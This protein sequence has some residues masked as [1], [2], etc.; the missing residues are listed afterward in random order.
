MKP[1]I[2]FLVAAAAMYAAAPACSE[3]PLAPLARCL[4]DRAIALADQGHADEARTEFLKAISLWRELG[5][6]FDPHRA[7]SMLQMASLLQLQGH[8]GPAIQNYE[9]ALALLRNSLGEKNERTGSAMVRL[10]GAYANVGQMDKAMPILKAA[11]APDSGLNVADRAIAWNSLGLD[12]GMR[13][14]YKSAIE[15]FRQAEAALRQGGDSDPAY[16]AVLCN[17]A[18]VYTANEEM[19]RAQPLLKKVRAIYEANL[20]PQ[21]PRI[22]AL[23]LQ[24]GAL[25]LHQHHFAEAEQFLQQSESMAESELPAGSDLLATHRMTL[26]LAYLKNG[27]IEEADRTLTPAFQV[28]TAMYPYPHRERAVAFERMAA[29][30]AAQHR[31]SEAGNLYREAIDTYEQA[32]GP[33][34][35]ELRI[36]LTD[37]AHFARSIRDQRLAKNLER[38]AKS[39]HSFQ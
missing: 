29:L 28:K 32:L 17:L 33:D 15:D 36:A 30:R 34:S 20:G 11:I 21:H 37:Y 2:S 39:I 24:E 26:G 19:D 4:H 27:K 25:A 16:G 6:Q 13:G 31:D 12:A 35:N 22:A 9:Q 3:Q 7:T 8:S 38:R 14:D 18:A 5:P 23:L 1:T 10:A